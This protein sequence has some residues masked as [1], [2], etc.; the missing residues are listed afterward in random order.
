MRSLK[1]LLGVKDIK[2]GGGEEDGELSCPRPPDPLPPGA[3]GWREPKKNRRR[4]SP[5]RRWVEWRSAGVLG[6]AAQSRT[7]TGSSMNT[8]RTTRV[9]PWFTYSTRTGRP[10]RMRVRTCSAVRTTP[11]GV[12]YTVSGPY[13]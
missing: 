10:A 13:V 7:R 8:R 3:A 11:P 12:E 1:Y 5:L 4:E 2:T 9:S 6:A